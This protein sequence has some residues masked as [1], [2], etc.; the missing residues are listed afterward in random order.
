MIS[1]T[2]PSSRLGILIA[3]PSIAQRSKRREWRLSKMIGENNEIRE[4]IGIFFSTSLI[5]FSIVLM[6][7]AAVG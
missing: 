6:L 1:A 4:A 2:L 7:I 3:Q 5:G